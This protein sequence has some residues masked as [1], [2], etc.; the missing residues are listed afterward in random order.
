MKELD[1]DELDRAVSSLMSDT[2]ATTS[3]DSSEVPKEKTLDIPSSAPATPP[4][5]FDT[6][7]PSV[8]KKA[9]E[10]PVDDDKVA[11]NTAP[12]IRRSS[13]RFMD[14]V[15]PSSDMKQPTQS[16]PQKPSSRQG[17]T[18]SP[19]PS[20]LVVPSKLPEI[21][22]DET[23]KAA[24]STHDSESDWPDPLD[25]SK[26]AEDDAHFDDL[27]ADVVPEDKAPLTSPFLSDAKVEKR[28]LG[29]AVPAVQEVSEV[30]ETKVEPSLETESVS[31]EQHIVA[32]GASPESQ[33]VS[34]P[35]DFAAPLPEELQ[36]DLV[37]IE[38][39]EAES[40]AKPEEPV[41]VA[42]SDRDKQP[43]QSTTRSTAEHPAKALIPD[44]FADEN[45]PK[46]PSS[47]AQQY[48]E[49]PKTGDQTNGAIYDTE[50]YHKPLAHPAKKSS[51]WLWIVWIVLILAIGA[52]I[53]AAL[54]YLGIVK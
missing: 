49:E 16:T 7:Q 11:V 8:V 14:V 35:I 19:I 3:P 18:I 48:K 46:G 20:P 44:H 45:T 41:V 21:V 5:S 23:P 43:V 15:H 33:N 50:A 31:Q 22:A 6:L 2:A 28:P 4:A 10:Q 53:G 29:G 42:S 13:G 9:I 54:Y 47:I 40:V 17:V 26:P 39:G 30:P 24:E 36:Q 51:G 52:G 12:A 1:F 25:I 38:S 32:D 27:P 37:A 34:N